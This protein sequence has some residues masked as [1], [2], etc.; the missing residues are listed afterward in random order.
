MI[1]GLFNLA[2]DIGLVSLS[3]DGIVDQTVLIQ[4]GFSA[5]LIDLCLCTVC[6]L[7]QSLNSK[8]NVFLKAIWNLLCLLLLPKPKNLLSESHV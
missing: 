2:K 5:A 8:L 6:K 4:L 7:S 3:S 1:L